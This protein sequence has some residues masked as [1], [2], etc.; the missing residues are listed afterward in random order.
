M[1]SSLGR[2]ASLSSRTSFFRD[3]PVLD[4]EDVLSQLA[5]DLLRV[6][7]L[8][9]LPDFIVKRF[10]RGFLGLASQTKNCL[11][12]KIQLPWDIVQGLDRW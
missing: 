11:L 2:R 7:D 4:I 12:G 3:N 8:V 6:L 9:Q 10:E 5:E 1:Y